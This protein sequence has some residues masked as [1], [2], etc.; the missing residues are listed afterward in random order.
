MDQRQCLVPI[1]YPIDLLYI[2]INM[3][4]LY[5]YAVFGP[6]KMRS[7]AI[8][9]D[10]W[11]K[12]WREIVWY[13]D[14][15]CDWRWRTT[16]IML[17]KWVHIDEMRNEKIIIIRAKVHH[18]HSRLFNIFPTWNISSTTHPHA[19]TTHTHTHTH[20]THTHTYIWKIYILVDPAHFVA[21]RKVTTF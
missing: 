11:I 12:M 8:N 18:Q 16:A 15:G 2:N 13:I 17:W 7:I 20:H 3:T 9:N 6:S 21:R 14:E 5:T 1:I 10:G 19:T 4:I